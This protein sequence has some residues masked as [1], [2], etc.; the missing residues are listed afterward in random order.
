MSRIDD[1]LKRLAGVAESESRT[2]S[3]LE[4]YAAEAKPRVEETKKPARTEE[5]KIANFVAAGPRAVD[6]K[7]PTPKPPAA[8][9]VSARPEPRVE[10][11]A[12]VDT[13]PLIEVRALLTYV[14]FVGRSVGRHKMLAVLTVALVMALTAAALMVLPKTYYIETTLLAQR[15]AV[16]TAL[17]NPGRAV[18]WDADAPTRAA[19]ETV[20]RRDNL[21][22][23]IEK[24]DLMTEWERTRAPILKFK[25]WLYEVVS[26]YKL[27]PEDKLDA[28]VGTLEARMVVNAGPVGDGTV[29]INLRWPDAEVGY[30]LVQAA[31]ESFLEARQQA[32]TTAISESI[33]ILERYSASLN[34]GVSRTLAELERSQPKAAAAT[35]RRR[36]VPRLPIAG[37]LTPLAAPALDT[38]ELTESLT[39]SPDLS[40]LKTQ[41]TV[42]KTELERLETTRQTQL[43]EAAAKL[44]QFRTV[45]TN[46][47]P[48]VQSAQQTVASL[49]QMSPQATRLEAEVEELQAEYDA[50][51]DE[52]TEQQI[53]VAIA[54]RPTTTPLATA[55]PAQEMAEPTPE[56]AT[57]ERGTPQAGLT[58]LRLRT[59]LNQLQSVLERTDAARIELAVSQAAFKYRYTVIRP[60]QVPKD[61]V[62]PR[63]NLMLAAGV[64][65]SLMLAL[66][67][68]VAK[69][70]LSNR[71]LE[72]WQIERQLGLPVVGT[73]RTA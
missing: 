7:A 41:I 31:Q 13:E 60:A 2:P 70:L 44:G 69:D 16:M 40:R 72:T 58:G 29:D 20:L 66:A 28:L 10:A 4:R 26:R 46:N 19:A 48:S 55:A 1:A 33:E 57:A 32:E 64:L 51:L 18:P 23:L 12:N 9:P 68:V 8:P 38:P 67:V 50:R 11:D 49:S 22:S 47:H 14:G 17:S 5:H 24:T 43:S 63:Y 52:A 54:R 36:V 15:N 56:P 62:F 21:I 73:L 27:T 35:P 61:P 59:E 39:N 34:E 53:K 37:G 25:D 3:M 65:A 45:Y 71:I 30:R 6:G 42:K